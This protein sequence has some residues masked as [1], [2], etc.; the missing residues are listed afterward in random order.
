MIVHKLDKEVNVP[1]PLQI[2]ERHVVE[3]IETSEKLLQLVVQLLRLAG[4]I[5]ILGSL[6]AQVM[7]LFASVTEPTISLG[8]ML[9]DIGI[10]GSRRNQGLRLFKWGELYTKALIPYAIGR[11]PVR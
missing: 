2:A 8:E 7:T 3:T 6:T 4:D 11:W 5:A 1:V 10:L 9:A